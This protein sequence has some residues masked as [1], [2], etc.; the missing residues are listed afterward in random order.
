MPS[1]KSGGGQLVVDTQSV[2]YSNFSTV[3]P[4]PLTIAAGS[5]ELGDTVNLSGVSVQIDSTAGL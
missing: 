1:T 4:I 3:Q 5:I 2:Y